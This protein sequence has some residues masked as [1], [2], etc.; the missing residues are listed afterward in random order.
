[1][2]KSPPKP[3]IEKCVEDNNEEE[4]QPGEPNNEEEAQSEEANNEEEAQSVETPLVVAKSIEKVE[5]KIDELKQLISDTSIK[6]K[7]E[8]NPRKS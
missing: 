5:Q 4:A 3:P 8:K 1:M 7:V 2:E 6:V